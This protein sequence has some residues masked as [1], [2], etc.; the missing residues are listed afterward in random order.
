MPL[1]DFFSWHKLLILSFLII[2]ISWHKILDFSF[3]MAD[4]TYTMASSTVYPASNIT[5]L[6]KITVTLVEYTYIQIYNI[7]CHPI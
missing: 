4:F 1:I 5:I 3:L 7:Y 6:A 2:L